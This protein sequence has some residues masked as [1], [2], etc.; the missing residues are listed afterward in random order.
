MKE[1]GDLQDG[2]SKDAA[3]GRS[4]ATS[5]DRGVLEGHFG[6]CCGRGKDCPTSTAAPVTGMSSGASGILEGFWLDPIESTGVCGREL[7]PG[8][9]DCPTSTAEPVA[10][11]SSGV[12]GILVGF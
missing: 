10:E 1:D 11:T 6:K 8:L 2:M 9:K 12:N 7:L 5:S 3:V 4:N